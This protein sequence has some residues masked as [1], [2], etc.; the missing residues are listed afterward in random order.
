M[1]ALR[2]STIARLAGV[3]T[4]SATAA[5]ANLSYNRATLLGNVVSDIR[6]QELNETRTMVDFTL[7][8]NR[9]HKN[10]EGETVQETDWHRIRTYVSPN[11]ANFYSDAL[12]KG[13]TVIVEGTIRYN[14]YTDKEGQQKNVTNIVADKVQN[15]G[16]YRRHHRESN[17]EGD[18]S[19]NESSY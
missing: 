13:T 3:R 17:E 16:E 2:T 8:T 14:S 18:E 5:A 10:R 11:R 7:A 1:F 15:L 4:F 19:S 12:K 6:S 9:Y